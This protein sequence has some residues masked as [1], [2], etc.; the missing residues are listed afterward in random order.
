[1]L[2]DVQ[3]ALAREYGQENW[4]ALKRAIGSRAEPAEPPVERPLLDMEAYDALAQDYVLAF[5]RDEA[6]LARLNR[7]YERDFTFDD[8]WAR[9]LAP[10]LR[11]PPAIV[12]GAGQL[13]AARRGPADSRA[14][15]GVRQL[16]RAA[17]RRAHRRALRCRPSR[18]TRKRTASTLS[19]TLTDREWDRLI[20]VMK[21]RGITALDAGGLMTDDVL[22][23]IAA[24]DHVTSLSLGGSRQL[25]DDG[26]R[27]LAR[28]PQLERLDL[29]EYPGGRLTDRGLEVLRHLPNLRHFEMTW[30][31]GITDKGVENLRFCDRLEVVNLMGSP[32]GDG[33]IR[34]LAGK[35]HLRRFSTGRLVTDEGLPLLH[36]FPRLKTWHG[37]PP[38][39]RRQGR[40]GRS[41][42]ICSSTARS[43]IAASPAW[44]VSKAWPI[45]ICSGTSPE[46]PQT[47]SRRCRECRT[48]SR[49]APTA[50]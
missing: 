19:G 30:Q 13:P 3:H 38:S 14:G 10:R 8:L 26:L 15:H 1:M 11:L 12:Q 18:S 49:S 41:S 27:H 6:A 48:C 36:A 45:S 4:I 5:G 37:P 21:E 39:A 29:S 2:R 35:P 25:T 16:G 42:D 43:P 17:G 46:S 24:L 40:R 44:P 32:T 34:A 33:A 23:R 28:M 47:A 20:A 50:G 7:H 31:S 9:D 22:A